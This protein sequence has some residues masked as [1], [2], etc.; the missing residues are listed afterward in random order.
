MFKNSQIYFARVVLFIL[1]FQSANAETY[2]DRGN[3]GSGSVN[4]G[5]VINNEKNG[6]VNIGNTGAL[7]Y[8]YVIKLPNGRNGMHPSL[9]LS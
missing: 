5:R 2:F 9:N 3:A 8:N 6:N 4:L 1:I 7:N